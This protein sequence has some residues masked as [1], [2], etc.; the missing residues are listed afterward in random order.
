MLPKIQNSALEIYEIR[1]NNTIACIFQDRPQP[2]GRAAA[3]SWAENKPKK[4][5]S[6]N[7]PFQASSPQQMQKQAQ[8]V[9]Q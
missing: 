7:L 9:S 8:K 5:L 1:P 4:C 3:R 2:T 6:R